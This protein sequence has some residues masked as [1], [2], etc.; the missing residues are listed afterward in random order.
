[1]F[2]L[3]LSI[4]CSVVLLINF[5]FFPKYGINT[6]QAIALNYV[7]CFGVGYLLK[8]AEVPFQL[9]FSADHTLPF[10]IL[11]L[12]FILTFVLS[13]IATQKAGMALT[14]LANNLSLIIPVLCS[15]FIFGNSQ[16]VFDTGN[17]AGMALAILAVGLATFK[18]FDKAK[19][20]ETGLGGSLILIIVFVLYG[21]TNTLI[22]YFNI[23]YLKDP[24]NVI[25]YTMLMVLGAVVAGMCGLLYNFFRKKEKIESKN[26]VAAITLGV[27]N[28]LSFYFLIMALQ[29]FANDGAFVYPI[30][31]IGV[32]VLSS[33]I[34][35]IIF[36]EKLSKLNIFGLFLAILA[37]AL[38][39]YQEIRGLV[40]KD[41]FCYNL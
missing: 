34:A 39:S 23:K 25:P 26:I 11:G 16:K 37:I 32:I 31:N 36:K 41:W 35:I 8:P 14:S 33:I 1:M 15:L 7:V 3:L 4:L 21:L 27:P 19:N 13:G 9:N 6:F 10:L 24:A 2:Y 29:H 22:N 38:L 12:G 20:K 28:F 17:Y 5:R 18:G 40:L 30:Y